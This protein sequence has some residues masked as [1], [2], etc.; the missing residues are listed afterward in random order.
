MG[1]AAEA[2]R[3]RVALAEAKRLGMEACELADEGWSY[4]GDYFTDKHECGGVAAIRA[5]LEAL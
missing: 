5:T 4:A 3:L 2:D 1:L